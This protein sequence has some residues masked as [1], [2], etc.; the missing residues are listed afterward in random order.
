MCIDIGWVQWK[1][2]NCVIQTTDSIGKTFHKWFAIALTQRRSVQTGSLCYPVFTLWASL[3]QNEWIIYVMAIQEK[4]HNPQ[5]QGYTTKHTWIISR[6]SNPVTID[7]RQ[8]CQC[9]LWG[10]RAKM[11]RPATTGVHEHHSINGAGRIIRLMEPSH[12]STWSEMCGINDV[13]I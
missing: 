11:M 13:A 8:S 1:W 10:D 12:S 3:S 4:Q 7:G 2:N 5:R 6:W 9:E